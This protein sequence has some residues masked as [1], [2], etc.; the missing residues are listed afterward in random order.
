V[1]MQLSIIIVNY[2]VKNLLRDCLNSIK[3]AT[4]EIISEIWVVDNNSDDD[5]VKMLKSEF[6]EINLIVNTEN[7][8]FSKANN[9]ALKRAKGKYILILNPDTIVNK[10]TLKDCINFCKTTLNCGGIGVKMVDENGY[11]LL[12][13]KRGFPSP[14]ASLCRGLKLSVLFPKSSFFNTYYLGHLHPDLCHK[15]EVLTGAFLFFKKNIFDNIGGLDESFFMY[16]EDIDY[17]YRISKAGYQNYY[18]GNTSIIHFKGK[19]SNIHS[20]EY[21][22]R[23][24][25]AMKIFSK[26]YYP[27]T[28]PVY[29]LVISSLMAFHY[30]RL[31]LFRK[32]QHK[33]HSV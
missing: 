4:E 9:Q 20:S 30:I 32:D 33:K 7:K 21:I 23:F 11:F 6:K 27:L 17:S 18:L 1:Y 13:S 19:S 29:H 5:S 24:F 14:W 25:G 26:K 28:Y 15:V 22:R 10:S 2:N 16:G 8:G 3:E 12:E 31:F